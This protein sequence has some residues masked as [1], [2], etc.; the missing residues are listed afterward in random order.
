MK[1]FIFLLRRDK[2]F[3]SIL[4]GQ[5]GVA[6]LP[7]SIGHAVGGVMSMQLENLGDYQ[8]KVGEG[9]YLFDVRLEKF[10][11]IK[12]SESEAGTAY[13]YGAYM[14]IKF[15]EP[16]LNTIYFESDIK[17]GETAI[18]PAGQ[19]SQEDFPAYQDA[20][21][22]V[23]SKLTDALKEPGSDWIKTASSNPKIE[24]QLTLARKILKECI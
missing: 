7:S 8:M 16:A 4:S 24:N 18:I 5:L 22:G 3:S 17:N 11:K 21:R 6:I 15:Y 19:I 1:E 9:D 20:I 10:A 12:A 13:V 14:N 2:K 23:F